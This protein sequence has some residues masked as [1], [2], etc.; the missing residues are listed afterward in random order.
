MSFEFG[1]AR[2]T[3]DEA[4]I[5]QAG[6]DWALALLYISMGKLGLSLAFLDANASPVWP[7]T[8]L[9]LAAML[10]LGYWTWPA[11]FIGA[12]YVN[13]TTTQTS[14][15]PLT[16]LA[17][18]VGNLS[19]AVLGA[20]LTRRLAKG[21]AAFDRAGDMWRYVLLAAI[22]STILSATIGVS[23]LVV[24]GIETREHFLPVWITWWMGNLISDLIVA[25]FLVI[26]LARPI[27]RVPVR[28]LAEAALLLVCVLVLSEVMFGVSFETHSDLYPVTPL[29]I[30]LLLWAGF[31]F[32]Q[33]G[34]IGTAA[35]MSAFAVSGTYAKYG[36][37]WVG[38]HANDSLLL[39]QMF[40]GTVTLTA[41]FVAAIV[42]ERQEL[43]EREKSAR[44]EAQ[45]ANEA[46]DRFLA[47]LSHELRTPLTP[48]LLT[49]SMLEKSGDLPDASL[50][51]VRMIRRN[52]E[53]EARLIDDLLDLSRIANGKMSL[54]KQVV[55]IHGLIE[56]VGNMVAGEAQSKGVSL[57]LEA[58]AKRDQVNADAVRLQQ[59]LWN[60]L[61]NAVKFTPAGG[62]I[63]VRTC[64]VG[65]GEAA[66]LVVEFQDDGVG[67]KP[68]TLSGL[69]RPFD[70]GGDQTTQRFGGLGLG[71]AISKAIVEMHGGEIMAQ[72]DGEGRGAKFT[73]TLPLAKVEEHA[74]PQP[75]PAQPFVPASDAAV[76]VLLVED[77]E[78]TLRMLRRLL[79]HSG[80]VVTGAD[81]IKAAL[82][83]VEAQAFDILVSDIGLGEES[84]YDLLREIRARGIEMPGI[85]LT[86]F[87]MDQDLTQSRL[88]GFATHL[89]KPVEVR[90]LV[91]AIREL[92]V[93]ETSGA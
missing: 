68:Q 5:D 39:L 3:G 31:R 47:V 20:M 82:A 59:V 2:L 58:A 40:M 89:T 49:A 87:G 22:P 62:R 79:E 72:S 92:M 6:G 44:A 7:P 93:R 56:A 88:A 83:C 54:D 32:H 65:E 13:L 4:A 11:I 51:D 19:E 75:G 43:F 25:P 67:I 71:L 66:R 60:L 33:R 74:A 17:I 77:H 48:V 35:V 36:P 14:H 9:A 41:L 55:K 76:R 34:A 21:T 1:F 16:C 91:A 50:A 24:G 12:F 85:A 86:G 38:G 29:G 28:R 42:A 15:A 81:S 80:F 61:K 69:F 23:A 90:N 73:V 52:V 63:F 70:Q 53:L 27:P 10:L 57:R 46:K 30:P 37:F 78:D 45:R 26:W 84:G 64:N 18:A 8:G